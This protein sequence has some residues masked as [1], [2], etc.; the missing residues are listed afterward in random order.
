MTTDTRNPG[1]P[2]AQ[3]AFE[4]KVV[5][6]TGAST[7][8]GR[9]TA[10]AFASAGARLMLG[11]IDKRSA[12]TAASIVAAGGEAR[13]VPTDV[14]DPESVRALVETIVQTYAG[15]TP[16]ST[17]PVSCLRPRTSQT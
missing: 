7:G 12:D 4:G 1:G 14:S 17:T 2:T 15:W 16:R 9:A 11:D 8:I 5:L 13:F 10:I 3:R 6:V